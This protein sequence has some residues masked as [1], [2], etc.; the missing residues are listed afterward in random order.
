MT[1]V[2][3]DGRSTPSLYT[4]LTRINT[5]IYLDPYSNRSYTYAQ[6]KQTAADFGKGLKGSWEWK[7]GDVIAL[8]TPNCI[9]TP[10][11]TWGALWAGGVVSPA[12]PGYSLSL[13]HI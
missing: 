2:R 3:I 5:V 4:S 8:Y 1:K 10:V 13:I 12:N 7:K 9:D 6:V 11:V